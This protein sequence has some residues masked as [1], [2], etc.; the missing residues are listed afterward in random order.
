[1]NSDTADHLRLTT[2]G[3]RA[4]PRTGPGGSCASHPEMAHAEVRRGERLIPKAVWTIAIVALALR[5]GMIVLLKAWEAPNPVEFHSLAI[6][7]LIGNGLSFGSWGHYGPSAVQTPTYAFILIAAFKIFGT[8]ASAA[9]VAVLVLNAL[10]GAF[11]VIPLFR[12]AKEFL[13]STKC[14][15]VTIVATAFWPTQI[16]LV[17]HAQAIA[18]ITLL[19]CC[20]GL[21][22]L[23]ATRSGAIWEWIGFCVSGALAALTEPVLLPVMAASAIAVLFLR[24][25]PLSRR[26]ILVSLLACAELCVQG[27]WILRNYMVFHALVPTKSSVWCNIWKGANP[28]ATGTDR[29]ANGDWRQIASIPENM[30]SQERLART[31]DSPHQYDM[32]TASQIAELQG[33][34]EMEQDKVFKRWSLDWIGQNPGK[35]LELCGVRFIKT[36]WLEWDNPKSRNILYVISRSVLLCMALVGAA[37]CCVRK[38]DLLFFAIL[39]FCTIATYTL[40]IAAARFTLPLEP[41]AI[42]LASAVFCLRR[43][44]HAVIAA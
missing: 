17:T 44:D 25:I 38:L 28:Y 18:L 33:K 4:L 9:Y 12:L 20:M 13:Q 5:L 2:P 32:L 6:S 35:W 3:Q 19:V 7:F 16:Y 22:F 15:Y 30:I 27:P 1:M 39:F 24:C 37:I 11:T 21:F 34:N 23:R 31:D 42:L 36:I 14:A 8:D 29:I 41:I 26:I 43:K 40:T 10:L